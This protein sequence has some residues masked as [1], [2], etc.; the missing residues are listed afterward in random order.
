VLQ[1]SVVEAGAEAFIP[2]DDL[3]LNVVKKWAD[4]P[5]S[6]RNEG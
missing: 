4:L 1:K 2:K 5:P 6:E 3:D